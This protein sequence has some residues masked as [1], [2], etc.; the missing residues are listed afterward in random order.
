MS[1]LAVCLVNILLYKTAYNPQIKATAL[2]VA[3]F[4]RLLVLVVKANC[5]LNVVN[6][7]S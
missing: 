2:K 6:K 4:D 5:S 7:T 1:E 3:A